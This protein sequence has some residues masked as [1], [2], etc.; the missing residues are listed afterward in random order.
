MTFFFGSNPFHKNP[1]I[2]AFYEWFPGKSGNG[3]RIHLYA[4]QKVIHNVERD[5]GMKVK[6]LMTANVTSVTES[7]SLQK[8]AQLMSSLNVGSLPVVQ[9]NRV[10]GVITDRDIVIKAV[11][12]G[13]IDDTVQCAMT[14]QAVTGTPDMDAHEAADLMAQHQIRRLPICDT[15]GNLVG[16]CSIGDLATVDIHVNE[17]GDALSKISEPSVLQ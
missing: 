13:K 14:R 6:D 11:A 16:I 8:G 7:D 12:K 3:F 17:A 9:N 1:S 10:V 4:H 5:D 15:S 2:D